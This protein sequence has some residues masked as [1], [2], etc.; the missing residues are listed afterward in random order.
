MMN[1]EQLLRY[2]RHI[3]LDD[4]DVAGQE[5]LLQASVLIIGAGGLGCPAAMYLA[6]SGV[7]YIILADDDHVDS[8]NLQRQIGHTE[9]RVNQA[10]V[11][12]LK[13][14]LQA[15]NS[16]AK[17]DVLEKRLNF[18]ELL[19]ILQKVNVVLDCSDNFAS[20]F[21]LNKAAFH[22]KTPLVSAA[23]IRSEGQLIT[24]DFREV[25]SPCYRCLYSDGDQADAPNCSETGVL[26]PVVGIVGSM[27]ALEAI[28][29]ISS[30]G[31]LQQKLKV[32]D[33]K[34]NQTRELNLKKDN[35]CPVCSGL[36][37]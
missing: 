33:F 24:F 28:K 32:M 34:Y 25:N 23:A 5:A 9:Q 37:L 31:E 6:S 10:K 30:F 7:G 26:A 21:L 36:Q 18:D 3:F 8:S 2:S 17:V 20:R 16:E 15:I 14:A 35:A 27:Q 11:E 4:F 19:E 29:V 1:D 13:Q 22:A 12:S